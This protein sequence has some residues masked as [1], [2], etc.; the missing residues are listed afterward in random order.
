ML[1]FSIACGSRARR[2]L[3]QGAVVRFPFETPGAV[4]ASFIHLKLGFCNQLHALS[5]RL[6]RPPERC[7]EKPALFAAREGAWEGEAPALPVLVTQ[8][9]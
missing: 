2:S 8:D 6:P 9:R 1:F 3:V 5:K 4:R 7:R